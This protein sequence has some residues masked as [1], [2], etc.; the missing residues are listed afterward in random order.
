MP[1]IRQGARE[2]LDAK[3]NPANIKLRA[4]AVFLEDGRN[5]EDA[6]S[7]VE[8]NI[9]TLQ[10]T[11]DEIDKHM[12]NGSLRADT[13]KRLETPRLI[14][15]VAFDGSKDIT[16]TAI[17]NGGTSSSCS[18]NAETATKLKTGAKIN[19]VLFDGSRDITITAAANGGNADT[20][21]GFHIQIAATA[22][23]IPGLW[24]W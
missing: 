11:V 10:T 8:S 23:N 2:L 4:L 7:N 24:A 1:N 12:N 5:V 6:I 3:N 13:A 17:A 15:G 14:N 21:D 19:N 16:I 9:N 20:V 18:G 22:Q